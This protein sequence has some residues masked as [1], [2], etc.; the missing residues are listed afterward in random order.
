MLEESNFKSDNKDQFWP[1]YLPATNFERRSDADV[2][3]FSNGNILNFVFEDHSNV[4]NFS[5]IHK[6][7][8]KR[9]FLIKNCATLCAT[10]MEI[11]QHSSTC[12]SLIK[13]TRA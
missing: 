4:A 5:N 7:T 9:T 10:K 13:G 3:N 12:T 2:A 1:C 11:Q 8:I 6:T